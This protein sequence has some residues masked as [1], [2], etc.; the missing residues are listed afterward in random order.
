M[1][2]THTCGELNKTHVGETV[3]LCGWVDSYRDHGGGLF[4]DLRDRYGLTQVVFNPPDTSPVEI[5]ASK[6]LRA[7][8]VVKVTGKVAERPEGMANP[9]LATGEV[10]VRVTRLEL[11]NKSKT[12]TVSPSSAKQ[13]LPGEDLRL[14]YRYLDLR[15]PEMQRV[16]MLRDRVVKGMR[17]FFADHDFIDVETPCLG[18]STPEGARDYLV[19]SRVHPGHF[20]ALPQSPQLYKQILMIA[21]YDRY[22]QVARCFRDED[23]RA[24]RQPEFTQLDVEMSFVDADD[25]MGEID[26]LCQKLAKQELGLDLQLPLPRMTYDEAMLRF[27][28]DAPDLRFGLEIVDCSDL[29]TKS[30]FGVFKSVV[31]SGG[32]VRAITV[33]KGTE[34]YSRRGIDGLTE[35]VQGL[36]AKGLAWFRCEEDGKLGSTIAKFFSDELLA[37]FAERL[38]AEPGDLVLFSAADWDMTCKVL[39]ALRTKI[40]REMKLYDPQAMHFS[41]V[42]EFPMF[43]QDEETGHWAAMHHPFTAPLDDH[44]PLLA[45]D[46]GKCRAKAYDLVINGSEAGGGTIRIHDADVQSQVF[47]LLGIDAE[48]ARDRFGFLL[49]A[50]QYG[51]PP[52]GGIALGIDRWVMLFGR[53]ESIRDCIAFPKTQKATDL[54]TEAPGTVDAKQLKELSIKTNL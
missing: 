12:P 41:W 4:V 9:K 31:K 43:A 51:A 22:V 49:D 44:V 3:T 20:Y 39:H 18:R 10:E 27:G 23:L 1:L 33:K 28:H 26:G 52:H 19:P 54:M 30:D 8:Y 32:F 7:E 5:E 29:A 47:G 34:Q 24:D 2:R 17:D 25:V 53:L 40:G 50:L 11:L 16:L 35:F 37:E 46:P 13:D 15:R 6:Q 45:T 21:G 14:Q 42:V 36:G 48:T 38:G